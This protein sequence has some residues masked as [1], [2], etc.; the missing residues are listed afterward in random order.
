MWLTRLL[1]KAWQI[2][3]RRRAASFHRATRRVAETQARLLVEILAANRESE[4]GRAHGFDRIS[5]PRDFQATISLADYADLAPQIERMTRG[6]QQVL[7]SEPVLLFEPTS[8]TTTG[9]KLIPYTSSLRRQFQAAIAVWMHDLLTKHPALQRGRAYWSISP[10]LARG[11]T[12]PAGIPIGFDDDQAYLGRFSQWAARQLSITPRELLQLSDPAEFRYRALYYLL[13]AEDLSLISI[14]N[15]TYLTT[16]LR[17]LEEAWPQLCRDLEQGIWPVP[18]RSMRARQRRAAELRRI[19]EATSTLPEKL[20]QLWPQLQLLSCWT[21]GAASQALPP[22]QKLLPHVEIQPKGLLATEAFVSIPLLDRRGA[23]LAIESHFFEFLTVNEQDQ[24]TAGVLLKTLLAH[25]LTLGGHYE[26][27]VTTG[28]GLYRYRMHDEIE[29]VGFENECP[30][31]RFVGKTDL[32]SDLV[33]EKLGASHVEQ[34]LETL[35]REFDWRPTFQLLAPCAEQTEQASSPAHYRLYLQLDQPATRWPE[36][37][38][39]L[40][41]LL[42]TNPYYKQAVQLGQLRPLVV[43]VLDPRCDAA[44]RYLARCNEW[45]QRLGN[46][47][48]SSLDR[49]LG[50]E[51]CFAPWIGQLVPAMADSNT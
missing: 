38:R 13:A 51:E 46:I 4:F 39:R 24:A 40:Q 20:R 14:W 49:R 26:V 32:T 31:V 47:K 33:G 11:R 19:M 2:G 45:G 43:A 34:A 30:L 12:T 1:N 16:I 25:E 7:T 37:A 27:I 9:E 3:C 35:G 21:D 50:W 23:A 48:P 41:A 22:L 44:Q 10:P 42:E 5:S 15:P 18:Q 8:G 36:L 17:P 29:I 6:E 28:G